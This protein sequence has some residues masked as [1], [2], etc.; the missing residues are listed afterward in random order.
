LSQPWNCLDD[1]EAEGLYR[2]GLEVAEAGAL[3]EVFNACKSI[4]S[5]DV[6]RFVS[7]HVV[8]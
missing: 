8:E 3:A 7:R 4:L 5:D 2:P 1:D 6:A